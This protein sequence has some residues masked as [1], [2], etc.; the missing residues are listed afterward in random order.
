MA[1]PVTDYNRNEVAP[2]SDDKGRVTR[3]AEELATIIFEKS[4]QTIKATTASVIPN[5]P[6]VFEDLTKKI[7]QGPINTFSRNIQ[8]VEKLIEKLGINLEDYN[9]KLATIIRERQEKAEKSMMV[10]ERLREENILARVNEQTKEVEVLTKAQIRQ[11]NLKLDKEVK[12]KETIEK[13]LQANRKELQEK[14]NLSNREKKIT[15]EKII[16]DTE[17]LEKTKQNIQKLE[18]TTGRQ[19]AST[20]ADRQEQPRFLQS[21]LDE[22]KAPFLA[23]KEGFGQI[24]ENLKDAKETFAFFLPKGMLSKGLKNVGKGLR[25]LGAFF[26]S[27]RVLIG[28]AIV[29]VIGV[30]LMFKDKLGKVTDFIKEIPSKITDFFKEGFTMF[31]D[32]FKDA[33]NG[34]I[35]LIREIPGLG[36]FGTLLETSKMKKEREEKEKIGAIEDS[37][38]TQ[39]KM[40]EAKGESEMAAAVTQKELSDF[41][42]EDLP[43]IV[44]EDQFK[45]MLE[46]Y[47]TDN[48]IDSLV[49]TQMKSSDD[50]TPNLDRKAPINI[51]NNNTAQ[52]TNQSSQGTTI[53]GF[54]N[55]KPDET[56]AKIHAGMV[57]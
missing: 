33:I 26:K 41:G 3:A 18:Q 42:N 15:R 46:N 11:E 53:A 50:L 2:D 35:K 23:F 7:E 17:A 38:I 25:A 52:Q 39:Q 49:S 22:F 40:L 55:N 14:D 31:T 8:Q 47:K 34:I 36:D 10:V 4:K 32:F 5:I 27:T 30:I 45:K 54:S 12:N 9:S 28:L 37:I 19:T 29:G 56:F 13:R 21:L 48:T 20:G 51:V 44:N 43:K 16:A 1:I 57:V 24:S 6:K